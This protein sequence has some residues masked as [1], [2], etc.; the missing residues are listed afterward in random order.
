MWP[1]HKLCCHHDGF[2][3]SLLFLWRLQR[4]CLYEK[5]LYEKLLSKYIF[6]IFTS[7]K[8]NSARIRQGK[9]GHLSRCCL[10]PVQMTN[11]HNP[12]LKFPQTCE[13]RISKFFEELLKCP[14]NMKWIFIYFTIFEYVVYYFGL[15]K[16]K[17]GFLVG[18]INRVYFK[19]VSIKSLKVNT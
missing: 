2:C 14:S 9:L 7:I 19:T 13:R 11:F 3:K 1:P 16:F 5:S 10:L 17:V 15:F 12:G 18:L 6:C 4:T 8:T